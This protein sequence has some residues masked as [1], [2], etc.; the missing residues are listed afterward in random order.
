MARLLSDVHVGD[1]VLTGGGVQAVVRDRDAAFQA[2]V[3]IVDGIFTG[4]CEG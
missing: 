4:D 1:L 2:W 3:G